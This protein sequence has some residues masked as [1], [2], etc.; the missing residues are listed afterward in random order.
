MEH[1]FAELADLVYKS[2]HYPGHLIVTRNAKTYPDGVWV[3]IIDD[4]A[5]K[6]YIEVAMR[7]AAANGEDPVNGIWY[8]KPKVHVYRQEEYL[9]DEQV[10]ELYEK[11][12]TNHADFLRY[13]KA[14][15]VEKIKASEF[16]KALNAVSTM[17]KAKN[18]SSSN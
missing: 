13:M 5:T 11:L 2:Q 12:P 3:S 6:S 10:A 9:T 15:S 8:H 1:D 4:R 7:E 17:E 16:S 14:D 18:D